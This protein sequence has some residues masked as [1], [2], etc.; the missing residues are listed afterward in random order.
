MSEK[1]CLICQPCGL[2]DIFYTQ[3][4][5]K[6]YYDLGYDI[7][8]P[9]IHEFA[10]LKDYIPYINWVS[11]EDQDNPIPGPPFKE[12]V[13]FPY[14]EK[15]NY[16]QPNILEGDFIYINGFLPPSEGELIMP[17]KY[18]NCNIDGEDWVDYL[19]FERNLTRENKLYQEV[20][21]EEGE[22][23]VL[24]NSLYQTR[25]R[26]SHASYIPTNPEH[27]GKTVVEWAIVDGY[28]PFD[29]L[30]VIENASSIVTIDTSIQYLIEKLSNKKA[31]EYICYPRRG[32][33]TVEQIEP[34]FKT[35][36]QYQ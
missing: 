24:V 17:F 15:Y 18:K 3:K 22:D 32:H 6:T 9:I 8:W 4:I 16:N 27:Y 30:K 14:K 35:P 10:F 34:L 26:I 11:W 33:K 5:A 36:W 21:L 23:Y 7:W 19:N 29:W 25:P 31:T 2:G 12:S 20:G 28:N 1:I 13:V